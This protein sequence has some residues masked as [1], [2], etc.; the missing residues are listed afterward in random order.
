MT[1]EETVRG[2]AG[3]VGRLGAAW[4]FDPATAARGKELGLS[5]WSFY[6]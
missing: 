5:S 6:H 2:V 1:P 4:M 3:P